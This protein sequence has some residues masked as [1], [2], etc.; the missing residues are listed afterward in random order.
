M[1]LQSVARNDSLFNAS[2]YE[3]RWAKENFMTAWDTWK[4]KV[5]LNSPNNPLITL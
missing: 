4:T 1:V 5:V 2:M 3:K